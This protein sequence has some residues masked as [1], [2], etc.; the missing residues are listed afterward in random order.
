M[1]NIV[2][3]LEFLIVLLHLP[4]AVVVEVVPQWMQGLNI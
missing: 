3:D 1:C 4:G 2:E